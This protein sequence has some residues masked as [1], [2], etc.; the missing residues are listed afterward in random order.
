MEMGIDLGKDIGS[1][2]M[3][4]MGE[5]GG[6]STMDSGLVFESGVISCVGRKMVAVSRFSTCG[7]VVT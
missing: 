7:E 4:V 2:C 5:R 3:V 1:A 6:G